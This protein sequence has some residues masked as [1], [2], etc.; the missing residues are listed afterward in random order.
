MLVVPSLD[1][2][3]EDYLVSWL[4]KLSSGSVA[5]QSCPT[6]GTA[7]GAW[8]F[9]SFH[10]CNSVCDYIHSIS[11]SWIHLVDPYHNQQGGVKIL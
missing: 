11:H 6:S 1:R 5:S 8:D 7:L 9:D 10:I 4:K 2:C 3:F